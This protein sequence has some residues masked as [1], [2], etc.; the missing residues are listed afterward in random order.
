M[1]SPPDPEAVPITETRHLPIATESGPF[2]T[3]ANLIPCTEQ[4]YD[5]VLVEW[6]WLAAT[7][8][9]FLLCYRTTTKL[10]T[11]KRSVERERDKREQLRDLWNTTDPATL[12][13]LCEYYVAGKI[14]WG[15][16]RV[17]D[18]VEQFPD[19]TMGFLRKLA[20]MGILTLYIQEGGSDTWGLTKVVRRLFHVPRFT[21]W[22]LWTRSKRRAYIEF[23]IPLP[24]EGY[25]ALDETRKN[26]LR[27]LR[28]PQNKHAAV[29]Q[30]PHKLRATTPRP[31]KGLPLETGSESRFRWRLSYHKDETLQEA[32]EKKPLT[33]VDWVRPGTCGLLEHGAFVFV[34]VEARDY[35]PAR[36]D[37]FVFKTVVDLGCK[38]LWTTEERI[39]N[40]HGFLA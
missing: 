24:P 23:A 6:P 33:W 8:A 18:M 22:T 1:T 17:K 12:C 39:R 30:Y 31:S 14:P 25:E 40:I 28:S 15:P 3:P 16:W 13:G 35:G 34:R 37:Q 26:L 27:F 9:F 36:L 5:L 7:F 19:P 11:H 10:A 4:L 38:E 29:I 21:N 20:K 2:A 32:L